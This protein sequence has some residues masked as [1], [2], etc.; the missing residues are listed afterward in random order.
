MRARLVIFTRTEG[1]RMKECIP[2]T[3]GELI[4]NINFPYGSIIDMEILVQCPPNAVQWGTKILFGNDDEEEYP[5]GWSYFLEIDTIR[6]ALSA[7]QINL[8][9]EGYVYTP[10]DADRLAAVVFYVLNDS[11]IPVDQLP[12]I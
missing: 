12:N 3:I 11:F 8:D 7:I 9:H 4:S 2:D 5:D 10:T 1:L 6:E